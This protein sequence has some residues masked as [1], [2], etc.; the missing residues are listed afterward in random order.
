MKLTNTWQ[1]I[2]NAW[3]K[4]TKDPHVFIEGKFPFTTK[5]KGKS[6]HLQL[7]KRKGD[8]SLAVFHFFD[9]INSHCSNEV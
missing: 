9:A 7:N 1:N 4:V 6:V 2:H 3:A 5:K 8:H